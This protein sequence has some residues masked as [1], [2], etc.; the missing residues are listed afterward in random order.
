[1]V[2]KLIVM[3]SL[4]VRLWHQCS[5]RWLHIFSQI[6]KPNAVT[7]TT[8]T[9]LRYCGRLNLVKIFN[10]SESLAENKPNNGFKGNTSTIIIGAYM[11]F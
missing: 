4:G 7:Q 6:V 1:M 3:F 9:T 5:Y 8:R 10:D 11:Y 2:G